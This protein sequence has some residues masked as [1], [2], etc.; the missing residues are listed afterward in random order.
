MVQVKEVYREKIKSTQIRMRIAA[1]A[2]ISDWAL[3]HQIRINSDLL[4]KYA[5][6]KGIAKACGVE[7]LAE[8]VEPKNLYANLT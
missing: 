3:S 8:L 4:T 5:V 7:D 6:L 2:G 1:D